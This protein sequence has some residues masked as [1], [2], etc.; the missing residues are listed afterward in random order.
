MRADGTLERR[1][2]PRLPRFFVTIGLAASAA[3]AD[4]SDRARTG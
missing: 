3:G 1:Q 2:S 4:G